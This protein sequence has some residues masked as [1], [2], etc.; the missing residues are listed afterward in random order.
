MCFWIK[1]IQM[2]NL[3][4]NRKLRNLRLLPG[5]SGIQKSYH[6]IQESRIPTR[7]FRNPGFLPGNPGIQDSYPEIQESRI[8]GRKSK[9]FQE[10]KHWVLIKCRY[11]FS[12]KVSTAKHK[13][14]TSW[15]DLNQTTIVGR[16]SRGGNWRCLWES[17][18]S[19][20]SAERLF[21][22]MS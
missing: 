3:D 9:I 2:L 16:L 11:S 22:L 7:K 13:R 10:V 20:R 1:C 5:S 8:P 6:E 18:G 12:L 4:P 19:R 15:S 17:R 14:A 21:R